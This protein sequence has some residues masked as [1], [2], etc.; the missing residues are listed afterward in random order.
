MK[1]EESMSYQN[2]CLT[3][4]ALTK[5][6]GMAK[7]V[8]KQTMAAVENQDKLQ[9]EEISLQKS[10]DVLD[11]L[12]ECWDFVE[13]NNVKVGLS[14]AHSTD[15][16]D[17]YEKMKLTRSASLDELKEFP[18]SEAS[19]QVFQIHCQKLYKKSQK[20]MFTLQN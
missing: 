20:K 19:I 18:P 7:E 3:S 12:D 15:G 6:L 16:K 17:K 9:V 14:K 10:F 5:S 4:S 13:N 8:P 2:D 11:N 1:E